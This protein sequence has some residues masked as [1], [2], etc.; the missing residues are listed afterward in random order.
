MIHY[1]HSFYFLLSLF[2]LGYLVVTIA[3][4]NNVKREYSVDCNVIYKPEGEETFVHQ[5]YSFSDLDK[6]QTVS[7][8]YLPIKNR[9]INEDHERAI[10]QMTMDEHIVIKNSSK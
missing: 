2:L 6:D 3:R 10:Q 1:F 5:H 7:N 9:H 8:G 4:Y